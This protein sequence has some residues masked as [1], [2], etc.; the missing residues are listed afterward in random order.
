ML[1]KGLHIIAASFPCQGERIY[2]RREVSCGQVRG[3][4]FCLFLAY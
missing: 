4:F 2:A 3:I 1:D